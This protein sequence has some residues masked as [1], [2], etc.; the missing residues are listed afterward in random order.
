MDIFGENFTLDG[1]L[2]ESVHLGDQ[3][4]VDS[5]KWS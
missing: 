1:V 5:R 4:S 3:F 2:E